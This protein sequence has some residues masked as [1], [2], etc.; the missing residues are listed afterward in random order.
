MEESVLC[1]SKYTEHKSITRKFR[2]PEKRASDHDRAHDG[3]VTDVPRVVR[4][5]V[6][7]HDATDSS[8]DEEADFCCRQ[9]VKRY[10]NEI[11]I[12]V[13]AASTVSNRKRTEA[14]ADVTTG[15]RRRIKV[16]SIKGSGRKF[17]GVRQR[18][19]GKWAAEI[20]DPARRVRL[21]LGTY[22]TAEEAAMV[23]DN[24]AIKLRGP[25]ALT[26][27]VTPPANEEND[28]KPETINVSS[29]SGYKSG[30]ESTHNLSSPTSVLN[31]RT[32]SSEETPVEPK[33]QAPEF[34]EEESKPP[35]SQ[36]QES[37]LNECQGET[38]TN[39]SDI[40]VFDLALDFPS[41]DELFDMSVSGLSVFDDAAMV[42]PDSTVFSDDFG[43]S[44]SS[45]MCQV[46]DYFADIDDLFF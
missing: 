16:S 7:D 36:Q 6:T 12:E 26:N 9:R 32:P 19:W 4:V 44:S 30:D 20:R 39:F 29:V 38:E 22:D 8:S 21:W 31:F 1:P 43:C 41:V 37:V 46:D 25:H 23:Y 27:F 13:V 2:K 5:S 24:A 45:T 33:K 35:P 34:Q 14:E 42:L 17:R 10:V 18:P 15:C 3:A 40:S 28:E 11:N